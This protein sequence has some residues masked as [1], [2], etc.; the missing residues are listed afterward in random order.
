MFDGTAFTE[1]PLADGV[2]FTTIQFI[3]EDRE[4]AIWVV[5]GKGL[6]RNVGGA[7]EPMVVV[8]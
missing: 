2:P 3:V 7:V 6:W 8:E 4:G 1:F 5:G